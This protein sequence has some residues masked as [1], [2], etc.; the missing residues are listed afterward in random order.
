MGVAW[1]WFGC[2]RNSAEHR[3]NSDA[4]YIL[5]WA[6]WMDIDTL[7]RDDRQVVTKKEPDSKVEVRLFIF[8]F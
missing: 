7:F 8:L 3:L 6:N 4:A 1:W 5:N 2:G